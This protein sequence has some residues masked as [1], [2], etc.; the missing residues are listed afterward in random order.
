MIFKV[1]CRISFVQRNY[2]SNLLLK[3]YLK[4]IFVII[5]VAL[6]NGS[7]VLITFSKKKN[8]SQVFILIIDYVAQVSDVWPSEFIYIYYKE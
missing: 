4:S 8:D 5:A 2:G 6:C 7:L 3:I 1:K